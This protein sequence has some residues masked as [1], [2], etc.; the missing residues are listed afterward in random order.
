MKTKII[1]KSQNQKNHFLAFSP[2]PWATAFIT[3]IVFAGTLHADTSLNKVRD[4]LVSQIG[5]SRL[6]QIKTDS[7]PTFTVFKLNNP[8]RVVVDISG[9]DVSDLSQPQLLEDPVLG[10]IATRQFSSSNQNV[11]RIILGFA[12]P[13]NYE[14]ASKADGL[15]IQVTPTAPEENP[16]S[17]IAPPSPPL[18]PK[19]KQRLAEKKR[20]LKEKENSLNAGKNSLQKKEK[21]IR[22]KNIK[23]IKSQ[24]ILEKKQNLIAE[25]QAVLKKEYSDITRQKNKLQEKENSLNTGENSLQKKEKEIREKNDKIIEAQAILEKKQNLIAEKQAVLKKE[26]SNITR[27]KKKLQEKENSLNIGENS[28][29]KKK[30]EIREKNIKLIKSQLI[31]REHQNLIVAKQATLNKKESNIRQQ[32]RRLHEKENS[33]KAGKNSLQE[34]EKEIRGKTLQLIKSQA[35][36]EKQQN[37]IAAKQAA[38]IKKESNLRLQK[39]KL[40][41][42][43]N[44]LKTG[45]SS[46]Q[47]KEREIREKNIKLIKSKAILEKQQNQIAAKQAALIKKDSNIKRKNHNLQEKENSLNTGE[48]SLQEKERKI[49]ERDL[50]LK[51]YQEILEKQQNQIAE[52]Q[53]AL[54][55][56][57]SNIRQ[58]KRNLQDKENSIKTGEKSLQEKEKEIRE[59]NLRLKNSQAML[60]KQQNQVTEKQ[61]A[62]SKRYSA[63]MVKETEINSKDGNLI[64]E[65]EQLNAKLENLASQEKE[66]SL[67]RK[68]NQKLEVTLKQERSELSEERKTFITHRLKTLKE[69][70]EQKENIQE[71]KKN[72]KR[73]QDARI[74]LYKNMRL[75]NQS[76]S[77]GVLTK[78]HHQSSTSGL[79]LKLN[80]KGNPQINILR[81]D[82][83]PRIV[84]DMQNTKLSSPQ[85]TLPLETKEAIKVRF[86]EHK[87][88]LR[89]VIDLKSNQLEHH[90]SR[91]DAGLVVNLN[92]RQKSLGTDK[93]KQELTDRHRK[94]Q[95]KEHDL[96]T[97][98][99]RLQEKESV[100]RT[101]NIKLEKAQ[102]SLQH[103]QSLVVAKQASWNRKY[104]NLK[105]KEVQIDAKSE[106]LKQEKGQLN[107][108]WEKL[109]TQEKEIS[110]RKKSNQKHEM[111]LKQERIELSQERKA[112]ITQKMEALDELKQQQQEFQEKKKNLKRENDYRRER[113]KNVR[114]PKQSTS[115]G[116]LTKVHHKSDINGLVLKLNLKGSPQINVQR[117]DTPPRLV[118]DM[119]NTKLSSPQKTYHLETDEAVK[120]RFGEHKDMLRAVIDLKS[121]HLAHHISRKE[122]GLM[123]SLNAG[124]NSLGVK[125]EGG[126]ESV[127]PLTIKNIRFER[128]GNIARII[129]E[130]PSAPLPNI[131]TRSKKALILNLANCVLPKSLE[132]SLDTKAYGTLVKMIS[133][134]QS[135]SGAPNVK[136]VAHVAGPAKHR[137]FRKGEEII[138]DIAPNQE[139]A[140]NESSSK[141]STPKTAGFSVAARGVSDAFITS[142]D[143]G[144][145]NK[146]L[147][148]RIT[149]D[150]KEA[151]ILTVLRMLSDISGENM[152]A[153]DAISGTVTIRLRN[154]PWD[155]ALDTILRTKGYARVRQNNIM[156]IAPAAV[157]RKEREQELAQQKAQIAIENMAIKLIT[158]NY[159]LASDIVGQIKPLLTERGSIQVDDRTNTIIVD[160]IISN[161]DRVVELSRRLDKQ[162]PQVL[163][164]S[165]IVEASSSESQGLGIQWGGLGQRTAAEGNPTGLQFPSNIVI[166]GA[167][168][169]G[170]TNTAANYSPSQYAVNL[171]APIGAG[172]GGGIG[173]IFGSAGGSQLLALRLS[174]MEERGSG[175]IISSPRITTL[176]NRTAK[177][178]SG[179]SI[180]VSTT[181]ANGTNTKF[182]AANLA[183]EVTPH[184]TNDGSVLMKIKTTKNE[185]DF[186]RTGGNGDPSILNKQAET[187]VLVADGDTTV[188]GGIY[189]RSNS[190]TYA[191]VPFFSD[192]PIIGWLFKKRSQ[193]DKRSELLIFITPRIVNREESL[194]QSNQSVLNED[195]R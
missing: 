117:L 156:R 131:D 192:I 23:L 119:Q 72:L 109:A 82:T 186:S 148:Q 125:G 20:K 43:E 84:I 86:G 177:I 36:I 18:D 160:D 161:I 15:E 29:Q 31:L 58:Q 75:P 187:E 144:Q 128:N 188:I 146:E 159:A 89:A 14:V 113:E 150:L 96:K 101:K 179:I 98:E 56:K 34:K 71:K 66:I 171:P 105:E 106:N 47:Q 73:E 162:I 104:S 27:Q 55:E 51:Q 145:K 127:E 123:V 33:L 85:K 163:I 74:E 164:E 168:S 178:S 182:V 103:Q 68:A 78:I 111:A 48:N 57:D 112:F 157:I 132:E 175:R 83:P 62:L 141:T 126:P 17:A 115:S 12:Q 7:K 69:L 129:V 8:L 185:A 120:V 50:E 4:L 97:A 64:Q 5:N 94:L 191:G 147:K 143:R 93:R 59:K 110:L 149:L 21:E 184:V 152:I 67:R 108:K 81:L 2:T 166:S 30:R 25:K 70:K 99:N 28:L 190:E 137:L 180:P 121:S 167:A 54:I 41:E 76:T 35:I 1:N 63:L 136:I 24:A 135:S 22:E 118:I 153:S 155:Q 32:K 102:A 183:L 39:K 154:V 38:L 26:Y 181:S 124:Q 60:E 9:G 49:R 133:S 65:R 19:E 87:N 100:I 61:A 42:K 90:I 45:E 53:A 3:L 46:L 151:E 11:G 193:Q 52:K 114:L 174:A 139:M 158:I 173:M 195:K 13:V 140:R 77:S 44:S 107:L 88:I 79:V 142:R 40:Q 170:Q 6:I 16:L 37:M 95:E 169:D 10:Q 130:V 176:D 189:T 116:T 172:V 138:W 92:V 134:Y 194:M 165:R 91:Q 122:E 80:L